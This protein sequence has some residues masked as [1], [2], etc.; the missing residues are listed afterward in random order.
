MFLAQTLSLNCPFSPFFP[1]QSNLLTLKVQFKD[2]NLWKVFPGSTFPPY[3]SYPHSTWFTAGRAFMWPNTISCSCVYLNHK[4]LKTRCHSSPSFV[5]GI[6]LTWSRLCI[7]SCWIKWA[8]FPR[9]CTDPVT[10]ERRA[11]WV[12]RGWSWWQPPCVIM[13]LPVNNGASAP[14]LRLWWRGNYLIRFGCLSHLFPP[15]HP[16]WQVH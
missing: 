11:S 13:P 10:W 12:T 16:F 14:G 7:N 9:S 6:C 15:S 1:L 8:T 3:P 2:D 5:L 4:L